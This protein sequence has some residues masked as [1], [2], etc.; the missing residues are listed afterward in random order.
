MAAVEEHIS[1]CQETFL[2][3]ICSRRQPAVLRNVEIGNARNLWTTEYLAK[4][5]GNIPVKIHVCPIPQMDFLRKNFLYKTLPFEDFIKRASKETQDEYFISPDEKYYLRSIGSANPRKDI[6]DIRKDFPA[7]AQDI[8]LTQLIPK[9]KFFSSVFR[10]GSANMQLWTHYDVMDNIL[11]QVVGRKRVVLFSPQD[12]LNLY[13]NGDKSQV[14]DIDNPDYDKYPKFKNA[15]K[16]ECILNPGDAIYIP[17]LWFHNVIA[18][19][20]SVAVNVFYK[21]LDEK[22]YDQ[23]DIYGNKD[24]I[25]ASRASQMIDKAIKM[26]DELPTEYKDFYSRVMVSKL[27]SKCFMDAKQL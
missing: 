11:I 9:E 5:I 3:E 25:P 16:Y 19:D 22:L 1:P 21:H 15:T 27:E 14:V 8:S 20:Y 23:K 7:I 12:A 4:S 10:I 18:L 6:A 2:N 24:P 17:A 13:L 26:L